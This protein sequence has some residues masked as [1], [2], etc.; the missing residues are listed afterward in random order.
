MTT[1]SNNDIACAI[2]LASKD[3]TG[4]HLESTLHNVVKF[5]ARK[6]LLLKK[7]AIILQLRKIIND[8]EGIVAA[9]V[10]SAKKLKEEIKRDLIHFLKKRYTAKEIY[11]SEEVEEKLLGG[12]RIEVNNEVIDLTLKNKIAKLQEYLNRNA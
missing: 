11:L 6:H 1:I 2:Y 7:D 5:L 9:R 12:V 4:V 8:E 10:S 3:K